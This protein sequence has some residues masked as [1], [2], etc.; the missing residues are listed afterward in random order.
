MVYVHMIAYSY[1]LDTTCICSQLQQILIYIH[2]YIT[3][4]RSVQNKVNNDSNDL[5]R[6]WNGLVSQ[7]RSWF[8]IYNN[9][10]NNKGQ[11]NLAIGGMERPGTLCNIMLLGA[12]QVSLQNGVSF[13]LPI[14]AECMN[15]TYIHTDEQSTHGNVSQ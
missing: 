12:T 8:I 10:N 4:G 1:E 5:N 2:T 3:S 9:N 7:C 6:R 15:V 11:S 14:L 13:H